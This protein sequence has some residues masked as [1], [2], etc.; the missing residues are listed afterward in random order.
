VSCEITTPSPRTKH[1]VGR[2]EDGRLR[3]LAGI[4]WG[5]DDLVGG[6]GRPAKEAKPGCQNAGA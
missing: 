6:V 1:A 2:V 4:E 5:D 3:A